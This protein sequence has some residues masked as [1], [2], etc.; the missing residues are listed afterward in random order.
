MEEGSLGWSVLV[1]NDQVRFHS[2]QTAAGNAEQVQKDSSDLSALSNQHWCPHA[3]SPTLCWTSLLGK[4]VKAYENDTSLFLTS[5]FPFWTARL[6]SIN[7]AAHWC[8]WSCWLFATTH[9]SGRNDS[10]QQNKRDPSKLL[11]GLCMM[12]ILNQT[13][14]L[15]ISALVSIIIRAAERWKCRREIQSTICLDG[16]DWGTRWHK[17]AV[18]PAEGICNWSRRGWNRPESAVVG[19]Y[20][21]R[22]LALILFADLGIAAIFMPEN[23]RSSMGNPWVA[24]KLVWS[25]E[26]ALCCRA[27]RLGWAQL[28]SLSL[29]CQAAAKGAARRHC[30]GAAL[31]SALLHPPWACCQTR[32]T[33]GTSP[34]L[35]P[36]PA[37]PHNLC[38][39]HSPWSF[40]QEVV[41]RKSHSQD[42][43]PCTNSVNRVRNSELFPRSHFTE[44]KKP[45]SALTQ[46]IQLWLKLKK[47]VLTSTRMTPAAWREWNLYLAQRHNPV[48]MLLSELLT[49]WRAYAIQIWMMPGNTAEL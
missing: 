2:N 23:T 9:E 40:V 36:S 6:V 24:S 21:H 20:Y 5:I 4:D 26:L 43:T 3:P 33:E 39:P 47:T 38:A 22:V 28:S 41:K 19:H 30:Q 44:S 46:I 1:S 35:L 31:T 29:Q 25:A 27:A 18:F 34:L 16:S 12:D 10:A 17:M 49:I 8:N 13:Q 11:V 48:K 32:G 37:L 42:N 14:I 7:T 45:I 15:P